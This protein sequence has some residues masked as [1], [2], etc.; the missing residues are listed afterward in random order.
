MDRFILAINKLDVIGES[1]DPDDIDYQWDYENNR[2]TEKL[3]RIIKTR[4]DDINEK[5]VDENLVT[6]DNDNAIL[7]QKVVFYSA[8]CDYNLGAFMLAVAK[9][10]N[11]GW[12]FPA[13]VGFDKL[14]KHD[15]NDVELINRLKL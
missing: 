1:V 11:R 7:T 9:A 3:K 12:V 10:G 15:K 4:L 5:L 6:I 8:A 2:P 14:T 13:S